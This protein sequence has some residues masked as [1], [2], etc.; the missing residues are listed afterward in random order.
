MDQKTEAIGKQIAKDFA[1][2]FTD[3]PYLHRIGKTVSALDAM[4][5]GVIA[6][7]LG[8]EDLVVQF[9]KFTRRASKR[10]VARPYLTDDL[11]ILSLAE[12]DREFPIFDKERLIENHL[13]IDQIFKHTLTGDQQQARSMCLSKGDLESLAA[14]QLALG[15]FYEADITQDMVA[16]DPSRVR[17]IQEIRAVELW[18]YG[19]HDDAKQLLDT[20]MVENISAQIMLCFLNREAWLGYPF[21]KR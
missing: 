3:D 20:L 13:S 10:D 14:V 12:I 2:S 6:R 16:D 19:H 7:L 1:E 9:E 15:Q 11:Q 21:A 17:A 18:R 5:A 4:Y 8:L